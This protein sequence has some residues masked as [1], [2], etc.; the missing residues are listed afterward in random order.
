MKK[1]KIP[2]EIINKEI[3]LD[4]KPECLKEKGCCFIY[5]IN[6]TSNQFLYKAFCFTMLY[7][8]KTNNCEQSVVGPSSILYHLKL[9]NIK[10]YVCGFNYLDK[11]K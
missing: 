5:G 11:T 10:K 3:C 9:I 6:T 7:C 4:W 2:Y 8:P 1:Y